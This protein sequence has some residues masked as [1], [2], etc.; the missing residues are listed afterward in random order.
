MKRTLVLILIVFLLCANAKA[1]EIKSKAKLLNEFN[2]QESIDLIQFQ[3]NETIEDEGIIIPKNSIIKANVLKFQKEKRW[4]KDGFILCKILNYK[5]CKTG[6]AVDISSKELYLTLKKYEKIDK[7]DAAITTAEIAGG[8]VASCFLPGV[9]I[10][11]FFTKG[12]ILRDKHPNWFKAGVHN[13]YDNSIFWFPQKGK[14]IDL[15]EGDEIKIKS[16]D[17]EKAAKLKEQIEI[18]NEKNL[19]EDEEK[20][21]KSLLRERK[22]LKKEHM[23]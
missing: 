19:L 15:N 12:A 7:V 23:L 6:E 14:K 18:E 11:Y 9:D 1:Q 20:V 5:D 17:K 13:A 8:T 21:V 16:L 3:T 10:V 2:T 22:K 4:H